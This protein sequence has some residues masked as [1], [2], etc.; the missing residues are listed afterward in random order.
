MF[1][2][3]HQADSTV[4]LI[5]FKLHIFI[6]VRKFYNLNQNFYSV[7]ILSKHFKNFTKAVIINR[8]WL[9]HFKQRLES[10]SHYLYDKNYGMFHPITLLSLVS[11][12]IKMKFLRHLLYAVHI[13]QRNVLKYNLK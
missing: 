13:D 8:V 6:F 5:L 1:H 7:H 9:L 2:L 10:K 11:I 4:F 3:L 12:L